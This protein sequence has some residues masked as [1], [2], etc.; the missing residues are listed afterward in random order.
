[1]KRGNGS[2]KK[3]NVAVMAEPTPLEEPGNGRQ[4]KSVRC[5]KMK[6]LESHKTE[7]VDEVLKESPSGKKIVS[8]DKSTSYVNINNHVGVHVSEVSGE[9]TTKHTL[10]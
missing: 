6:V 5:F 9:Y 10:K 3:S 1:M 4:S 7:A 2:Q 8:G